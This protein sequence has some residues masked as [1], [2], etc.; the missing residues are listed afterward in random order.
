VIAAW[1]LGLGCGQ[2]PPPSEPQSV[3]PDDR[4]HVVL[5]T[6][7][8]TRA[9]H[10]GAYGRAQARTPT[11]DAW[12]AAGERY[13]RAFSPVPL[14]IP[15]HAT[16]LTG[17]Q[18]YH[19]GVRDNGSAVLAPEHVTL[20]EHLGAAGW[21]T[22]ASV[23]AYVTQRRWG[24]CQG[25][26]TCL[27]E[28]PAPA[29]GSQASWGLERPADQVVDDALTWWA[30]RDP[31]APAHLW[32]HLYD[33]HRPFT[34]PEPYA[35]ALAGLPYD[36]EIAAVDAQLARLQARLSGG[37]RDILWVIAGDHGE[38][39]GGHNERE[40]GWYVYNA[41]QRVPLILSGAGVVPAVVTQPVGLVDVLPTVLRRLD[42]PVPAELDGHAQP[43]SPQPVYLESFALLDL[44]G[45]APH[46]AVVDGRWKLIATPR[47]ELYDLDADLREQHDL[48]QDH[49]DE[50]ARLQALL[51]G[52]GATDPTDQASPD[53]ATLAR[54]QAL[55]YV[56]GGGG[57]D[58]AGAADPKD[59]QDVL[60]RVVRSEEFLEQGDRARAETV[61]REAL[62]FDPDAGEVRFRLA[63]L[64]ARSDRTT[65]AGAELTRLLQGDRRSEASCASAA[66]LLG[67]V[68]DHSGAL[69]LVDD[70][71]TTFPDARVLRELLLTSLLNL[72]RAS[73][74][75]ARGLGYGTGHTDQPALSALIGLS[76]VRGGR[77]D[78]AAP[79]LQAGLRA[80]TVTRDVR[81]ALAGFAR[82]PDDARAL[83]EAEL[84]AYPDNWDARLDLVTLTN[85]AGDHDASLLHARALL[86]QDPES[87]AAHHAAAQALF[88]LDR[89]AAALAAL[90][91]ATDR[92]PRD[93]DL[94]LL[95]ANTQQALGDEAAALE[96]RDRAQVLHEARTVSP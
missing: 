51:A 71:L 34:P 23:S 74:A 19:H 55:G 39:L 94:V 86:A 79:W 59:M 45:Y 29:P 12:A 89:H 21:Q 28:L 8:T 62:D 95:L 25:Y 68:G 69:I 67:V 88:N 90:T 91:A 42:L 64:L 16:L 37:E 75:A 13:D 73:E 54:L 20:A 10:L 3:A 63:S 44:Y 72:D 84:A 38:G 2:A 4:P 93:P 6:L 81:Y 61:L 83:L 50:V 52:L 18:P 87:P 36:A 31:S 22:A 35:T 24:L 32:L 56:S 76:M 80:E 66:S 9:D 33:A 5:I 43:G 82:T 30:T 46:Q 96:T 47:P 70:C 92:F 58:R 77:Q 17:L 7:D 57:G 78:Q 60:G 27:D 15:S 1:A 48:S 85:R 11:L 49:P 40:H 53:A 65:E 26:D 14:T 41:T